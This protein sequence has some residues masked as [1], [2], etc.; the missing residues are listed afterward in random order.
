M[1]ESCNILYA[2]IHSQLLA[3]EEQGSTNV[4]TDDGTIELHFINGHSACIRFPRNPNV[5][6]LNRLSPDK[7]KRTAVISAFLSREL[8]HLSW[9]EDDYL[10]NPKPVGVDYAPLDEACKRIEALR[11]GT[12]QQ[13]ELKDI[14]A[15]VADAMYVEL[16]EYSKILGHCF[17]HLELRQFRPNNSIG[18]SYPSGTKATYSNGTIAYNTS[19]L[20]KNPQ[21]IRITLIHEL[22]HDGLSGHGP[23][24]AKRMEDSFLKLGY[25]ERPCVYAKE[26]R[27]NCGSPL[28]PI[29]Q[30]ETGIHGDCHNIFKGLKEVR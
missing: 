5:Y 2:G 17:K 12:Y 13:S 20:S 26:Y 11:P 29:R 8:L 14:L 6:C 22:C 23:V 9:K 24:F 28:F 7:E 18:I 4:C 1:E 30:K 25:I 3:A 27:D 15:D 21:N 10:V 19:Y 16:Y